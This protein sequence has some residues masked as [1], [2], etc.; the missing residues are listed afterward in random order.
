MNKAVVGGLAVL[1]LTIGGA[2]CGDTVSGTAAD[3]DTIIDAVQT[4]DPQVIDDACRE[5]E[6]LGEAEAREL[7]EIGYLSEN[8]DEIAATADEAF[9]ALVSEC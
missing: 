6:V 3:G 9:D 7:F 2:G 8:P 5:L 4:V 1:A